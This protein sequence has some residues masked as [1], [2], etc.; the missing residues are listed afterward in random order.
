MDLFL[1]V[2]HRCLDLACQQAYIRYWQHANN[3]QMIQRLCLQKK[4]KTLGLPELSYEA[5]RRYFPLSGYAQYK[6]KIE[7]S[8]LYGENPLGLEKISHFQTEEIGIQKTKFIPYTPSFVEDLDRA[9]SVWVVGLYQQYP[10]LK[11]S[12][13][14]WEMTRYPQMEMPQK[15]TIFKDG[16]CLNQTKRLL[17]DAVRAV[18]SEV[19]LAKSEEERL[20]AIATFL[21]AD[22]QLGLI[23]VWHSDSALS[24]LDIICQHKDQIVEVL[25]TGR[26][27]HR[28]LKYLI[29]PRNCEQSYKLERLD[30]KTADAWQALWPNLQLVSCWTDTKHQ[31]ATQKLK[32]CLPHVTFESKGVWRSE[33]VVTI[34]FQERHPLAYHSHFYEF[35]HVETKQVIPSWELKHHDLVCPVLTTSAGLVRYL[36]NDVLEVTDFYMEIPC[37]KFLGRHNEENLLQQEIS[38]E[39]LKKIIEDFKPMRSYANV[40]SDIL[41][42]N[43]QSMKYG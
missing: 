28:G 27:P 6:K 3:M 14:Y 15:Q 5:F 36:L 16:L 2:S 37:F 18:P 33:G 26:W 40:V 11:N 1:S 22:K 4:L 12:S 17:N 23:S 34:P 10:Q 20:F 24:L 29:A 32:Q 7:H 38:E 25:R 39:S 30:L 9:L 8:L 21:V 31:H 41:E 42:F 13:I 43:V 19:N 35:L